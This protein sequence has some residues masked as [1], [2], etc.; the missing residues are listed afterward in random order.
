MLIRQEAVQSLDPVKGHHW[1]MLHV[2]TMIL[3]LNSSALEM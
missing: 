3:P 1:L 2:G